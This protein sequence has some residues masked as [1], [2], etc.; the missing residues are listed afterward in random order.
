MVTGA[1]R[2]A[3][4]EG[5]DA[6]MSPEEKAAFRENALMSPEQAAQVILYGVRSDHCR[7]HVGADG[8]MFDEIVRK[9][10]LAVYG[11]NGIWFEDFFTKDSLTVQK[12]LAASDPAPRPATTACG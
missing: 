9:V 4:L 1:D 3:T 12:A 6:A 5:A 7:I 2:R 8:K 10:P 11:E